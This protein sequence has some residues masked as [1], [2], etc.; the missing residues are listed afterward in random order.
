MV[1]SGTSR[2]RDRRPAVP[3]TTRDRPNAN[4]EQVTGG[5]FDVT[6]QKLLEGRDVHRR[7]PRRPAARRRSST[8]RSRPA[9][10]PRERDRPALPDRQSPTA[11]SS[12]RG[13]RS[14]A[15]CPRSACSARSTTRAWTRPAST[16]RSSRRPAGPLTPGPFVN[17][18]AT[19]VVKPRPGQSLDALRERAAPRGE[20]G[21]SEPAALFRRHAAEPDR[22]LRRPEPH[23]RDDV[24]RS[25]ASWRS[26]SPRS[27]IYGVM[28]FSVNQRT[29]EFG[30]RMA[31]GADARR[32]LAMVLRQ[33]GVQ[34]AIGLVLG[35]G[36]A[37]GLAAAIGAGDPEHP[38]RR[39]RAGSDDVRV[40]R[41]ARG[42]RVARGDARAGASRDAR[43]SDDGAA[44]GL[45]TEVTGSHWCCRSS[46]LHGVGARSRCL[47]PRTVHPDA[48]RAT[49]V[50]ISWAVA[51]EPCAPYGTASR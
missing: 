39:E 17:Q 24:L 13:A 14:S 3:R 1:F 34:I 20:Q 46:G 10:R 40:G 23:H 21:R 37:F 12:D 49:L 42:D 33:G 8:R 36:L 29:Q 18:F 48:H 31:L 7:R 45:S 32:I 5:F 35:L 25:S 2:D 44:R 38:V 51:L 15:S 22:R 9:L 6:A 30:V 26:S 19:V 4:F 43:P 16:C 47:R 11:R 27:G 41:G 28:S 50:A